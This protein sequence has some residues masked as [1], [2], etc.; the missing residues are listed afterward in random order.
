MAQPARHTLW[1]NKTPP[2]KADSSLNQL[3]LLAARSPQGVFV[4]RHSTKTHP[5]HTVFAPV[6]SFDTTGATTIRG[7]QLGVITVVHR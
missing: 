4:A 7:R 5:V 6:A 2:T 1:F 3:T